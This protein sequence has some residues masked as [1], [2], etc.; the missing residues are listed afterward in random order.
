MGFFILF[1]VAVAL[2]LTP[3]CPENG[4]CM[5]AFAFS[6]QTYFKGLENSSLLCL[7]GCLPF[8]LPFLHPDALTLL[9]LEE[10]PSVLLAFRAELLAVISFLHI[11]CV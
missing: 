1:F 2:C 9:L 4:V 6:H 11:A 8:L 5:T 7:P 10:L 3:A